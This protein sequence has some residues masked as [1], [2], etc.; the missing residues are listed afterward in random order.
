MDGFDSQSGMPP[1]AEI[2]GKY[3]C[4]GESLPIDRS[5]HLARLAAGYDGCRDCEH[6]CKTGTL[7][8]QVVKGL[9]TRSE[10]FEKQ[11]FAPNRGV[12]LNELTRPI[13]VNIVE[14]AVEMLEESKVQSPES[15]EEKTT[16]DSGLS[17]LVTSPRILVAHD[18]RPSS[19]DLVIGVVAA[20]RRWGCEIVD[21]GL[22]S[23]S[24]FD[25]AMGQFH[26]DLG[27]YVT[28]GNEPEKVNGLD[29]IGSTGIE[30]GHPGRLS[31]LQNRLDQPANRSR[32]QAGNYQ[33]IPVQEMYESQ[34]ATQFVGINSLRIAL[35]CGEPMTM[36]ILGSSLLDQGCEVQF[37]NCNFSAPDFRKQIE[38]FRNA[39]R[40][41]HVDVGFLI[42]PNGQSTLVFDERAKQLTTAALLNLLSSQG[43]SRH[44]LKPTQSVEELLIQM[45]QA[46]GAIAT[47]NAG[48]FWFTDHNPKCDTMNVVSRILKAMMNT[49][50]PLS[51][52]GKES[53]V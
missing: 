36:Q 29:I 16:L 3:L 11:T 32:R 13:M 51:A 10:G 45:K 2:T 21:L 33:A 28:G 44:I 7:P 27:L 39:M 40:D 18:W 8:K 37:M 48:R 31:E 50:W 19:P 43:S 20:L 26:A 30:W 15:R 35:A 42:R 22:I 9:G 25:F 47:D 23:R 1:Q 34:S 53:K 49:D 17:T 5:L 14:H 4:P 24:C 6:R 52:M 41:S 38:Q 12:Y 46:S